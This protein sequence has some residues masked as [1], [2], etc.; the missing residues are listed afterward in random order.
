VTT[1]TSARRWA[2]I[3]IMLILAL[4][5]GLPGPWMQH[6]D[7]TAS[8]S[9]TIALDPASSSLG[10]GQ[11]TWITI[12]INNVLD[13][14]GADVRLYFNPSIIEIMDAVPG[15]PISLEQGTAPWPDF[16]IK[17]QA[18]NG[19]GD[20][21]YAATQLNP[22]D[23]FQGSGTMARI[24]VRGLAEGSTSIAFIN[25]DL[26]TRNGMSIE[27]GVSSCTVQVGPPGSETD[28]PTPTATDAPETS[29]PTVTETSSG[30]ATPT[31][32][33]TTSLTP[34]IS[35]TPSN[36]PT[37]TGTTVATQHT[38][39]GH[40]YEGGIGDTSR[41]MAG[42]TVYLKGSHS[43]GHPGT[44]L[45]EGIT[46]HQGQF[47]ISYTGSYPHYSLIELDP[48]GYASSGAIAGSGGIVPD[49][50]GNWVEYRNATPG[51][52]SGTGFFDYATAEMTPTQT[53]EATS[54]HTPTMDPN[55]TATPTASATASTP[56]P[57]V[58]PD[59]P[60]Y[61]SQRAG[62][63]T[64]VSE[65][66]P[67]TEHGGLG[68]LHF[69]KGGYG[70]TK[71]VLIWF[72]LS[73]IPVGAI[74]REALLD[75]YSKAAF[76]TPGME[77]IP[78]QVYGLKQDW[79]ERE[80][81]W[82]WPATGA[83]WEKDGALDTI[84]D[85]DALGM[86]GEMIAS[87]DVRAYEWDVRALVQEWANGRPN[88]GMLLMIPPE[89]QRAISTMG[90]F[91]SEYALADSGGEYFLTPFLSVLYV[92]PTPTPTATAT[93]TETATPTTT[94]TQTQTPT[95]TPQP[96]ATMTPDAQGWLCLPV[97]IKRWP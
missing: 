18:D 69:G 7:L 73:E 65:L 11:D 90:F 94:A 2:P 46:N 27:A 21:W 58:P 10:V 48:T 66:E 93:P 16:V 12:R 14:Y 3:A 78:L 5:V 37:P 71:N 8:A 23:P 34:S 77:T 55:M 91:S 1:S 75:I 68:H 51:I 19:T 86:P 42:V 13:L 33:P 17:N 38:F 70:P 95:I 4:L 76:I 72:D 79:Q 20:I 15:A 49:S 82:Y 36:T 47:S 31:Q 62:K 96:T 60:V 44:Y 88:Q 92:V 53:Q 29:T 74:I 64:F 9:V 22:R 32:T 45:T 39:T 50:T 81:T 43:A 41:P 57:T 61:T 56:E 63:D 87:G 26:V 24:H 30:S 28:T 85:R 84:M 25:Y 89:A 80:A 52:H 97:V 54:T 35:P 59:V 83:N 40:V 67:D 6:L